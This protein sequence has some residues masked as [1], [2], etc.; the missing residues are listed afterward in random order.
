MP[1]LL[2]VLALRNPRYRTASLCPISH[3]CPNPHFG[4]VK[5][6]SSPFKRILFPGYSVLNKLLQP[7]R[8][9]SKKKKYRAECSRLFVLGNCNPTPPPSIHTSFPPGKTFLFWTSRTLAYPLVG[10]L[11]PGSKHYLQVL[12]AS[13]TRGRHKK[14][15]PSLFASDFHGIL[16]LPDR[17]SGRKAEEVAPVPTA[18]CG[19]YQSPT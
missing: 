7:V 3:S 4:G 5:R 6:L 17:A 11:A 2:A 16:N 8:G 9:Q 12:G 19:W 14:H 10:S 15:P 1:L 18:N 13:E